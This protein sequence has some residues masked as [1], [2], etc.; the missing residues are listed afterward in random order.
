MSSAVSLASS[1]A[2]CWTRSWKPLNVR[3]SLERG[4]FPTIDTTKA[5]RKQSL[6]QAVLFVLTFYFKS[7]S[8][9]VLI[10]ELFDGLEHGHQSAYNTPLSNVRV[11]I[12]VNKNE[13]CNVL[14]DLTNRNVQFALRS[15]VP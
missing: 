2:M 10:H 13:P 15:R 4:G 6:L 14:R 7:T 1:G 5:S 9:I 3:R 8:A 12:S 11:E